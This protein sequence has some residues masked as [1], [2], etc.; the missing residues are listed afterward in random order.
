MTAG[1]NDQR[2]KVRACITA[3]AQGVVETQRKVS[4]MIRHNASRNREV[5]LSKKLMWRTSGTGC[6]APGHSAS[7]TGP[8]VA[9]FKELFKVKCYHFSKL[10]SL[11]HKQDAW[12]HSTTVRTD[13]PAVLLQRIGCIFR[14]GFGSSERPADRAV[15]WG[16]SSLSTLIGFGFAPFLQ[17]DV[18]SGLGRTRP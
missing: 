10:H 16:V 3:I 4:S 18:Y 8:H 12:R 5:N 13:W 11:S 6:R 2:V 15:Y 7:Y 14:D 9:N 1:R 17:Y